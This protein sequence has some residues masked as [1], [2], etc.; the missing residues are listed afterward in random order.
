MPHYAKHIVLNRLELRASQLQDAADALP[1]GDER[2][3]LLNR[4]RRMEKA[5]DVIDRWISS[6]ELR[7]PK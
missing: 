7:A 6:P 1:H 5:S 2:D 3:A 4:V